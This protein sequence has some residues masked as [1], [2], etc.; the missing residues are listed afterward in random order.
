MACCVIN[1][2]NRSSKKL[3]EFVLWEPRMSAQQTLQ[4][5]ELHCQVWLKIVAKVLA[6]QDS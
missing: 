3:V 4:S 6:R 1:F 5:L 2:T